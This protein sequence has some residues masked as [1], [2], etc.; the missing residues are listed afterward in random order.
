MLALML[1]IKLLKVPGQANVLAVSTPFIME[2]LHLSSATYATSF[3]SATLLAALFQPLFGWALDRF[4]A[5][6]CIP[7]GLLALAGGL[8]LL[9]K[10]G[11]PVTLGLSFISLRA[12]VIGCLEAWPNAVVAIWFKRLRGRAIGALL[13]VSGLPAG[14]SAE[15]MQRC[16]EAIGWRRTHELAAWVLG[17]L[18][19]V[20]VLMLRDRPESVGQRVDGDGDDDDD[21]SG[22][23][24]KARARARV[25]AVEL[26]HVE[27]P[28]GGEANHTCSRTADKAEAV[29]VGR[30]EGA[31]GTQAEV[32]AATEAEV[33]GAEVEV[34]ADGVCSFALAVLYASMMS[35]TTIC[36]GIDLFTA[37][38]AHEHGSE[39]DV[40]A[41]VFLPQ[42]LLLSV[43]GLLTGLALDRGCPPNRALSA[44]LAG[45]GAAACVG[46]Y[47]GSR[48]G[49]LAYG[50][51]RGVANAVFFA[52]IVQC[53]PFYFGTAR[54]GLVLGGN[55]L[56][57]VAGTCVGA[58]V[59]GSSPALFGSFAPGL[60]ALSLP[61]FLLAA[62]LLLLPRLLPT[63][64]RQ[65]RQ[66]H[67]SRP[68]PSATTATG[69]A[70]ASADGGG[71][72]S[73]GCCAGGF[74]LRA[75]V[76]S[77]RSDDALITREQTDTSAAA[78]AD[79]D[80]DDDF[81]DALSASAT[82]ERV[83]ALLQE[84]QEQQLQKHQVSDEVPAWVAPA[85][86]NHD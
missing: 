43:F 84:L 35:A 5:R 71:D 15:L 67:H 81:E 25:A 39:I 47:M 78:A 4:G 55:A 73:G 42:G 31:R 59:V 56:F 62:L 83:P 66:A 44:G 51:A 46:C 6:A 74:G 11:D 36:G 8:V 21:A 37:N 41:Y 48:A 24:S 52:A 18:A 26:E 20:C 86:S 40:A 57:M 76:G 70:G 3:A 80:D 30:S 16:D 34:G 64:H 72:G 60:V 65:K 53:Y 85:G 54:I 58:W 14:I 13:V 27:R 77:C 38:I 68:Q 19:A 23:R 69:A 7:V 32:E 2:D 45:L 17:G 50:L 63:R 28:S 61:A 29:P 49:A 33:A 9:S 10:A 82:H 75:S 79:D 12:T 22:V 1:V